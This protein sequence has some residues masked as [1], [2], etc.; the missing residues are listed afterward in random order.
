MVIWAPGCAAYQQPHCI[1]QLWQ[2]SGIHDAVAAAVTLSGDTWTMQLLTAAWNDLAPRCE[3][4]WHLF[5]E[6][7]MIPTRQWIDQPTNPCESCPCQCSLFFPH[8]RMEESIMSMLKMLSHARRPWPKPPGCHG[9]TAAPC[10]GH[11]SN[12]DS[13]SLQG[14]ETRCAAVWWRAQHSP[15]GPWRTKRSTAGLP[16]NV[17]SAVE[18]LAQITGY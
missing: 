16:E 10:L 2:P 7:N 5:L 12:E 11:R 4:E 15:R 9:P 14:P 6:E 13:S 8:Q 1:H 17:G 3:V 18:A